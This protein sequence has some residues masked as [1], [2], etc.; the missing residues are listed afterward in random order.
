M[1]Q[2]FEEGGYVVVG[3]RALTA[4]PPRQRGVRVLAVVPPGTEE[5]PADAVLRLPAAPG[6]LLA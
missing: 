2:L 6:D 1:R 3:R 4:P 5:P